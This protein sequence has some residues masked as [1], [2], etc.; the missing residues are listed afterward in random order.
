[1]GTGED[2]HGWEF[3]RIGEDSTEKERLGLEKEMEAIEAK[4]R[5]MEEARRRLAVIERELSMSDDT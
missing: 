3:V 4:L 1:M 2:G 5:S